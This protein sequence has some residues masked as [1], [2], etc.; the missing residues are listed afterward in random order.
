M[1]SRL[2]EIFDRIP[3]EPPRS[4]LE[5]Y[6]ELILLWRRQGRPYRKICR[7]LNEE[8]KVKVSYGTLYEFVERRS[9]P[10][11]TGVKSEREVAGTNLT[12]GPSW[13]G[14]PV[15][16]KRRKLSPEEIQ[17]QREYVRSLARKPAET[18]VGNTQELFVYDPS[19]PLT[20]KP[21]KE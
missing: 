3:A 21:T 17:A 13:S 9:R 15:E 1:E 19:Q 16:E 2:K 20:N 5:P 10:R 14:G 18:S 6:R 11:K 7:L 8:C 12:D 4:R